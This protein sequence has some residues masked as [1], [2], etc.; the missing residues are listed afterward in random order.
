MVLMLQ[1]LKLGGNLEFSWYSCNI[2]KILFKPMHNLIDL[3][4]IF[5]SSE[6]ESCTEKVYS[7][8]HYVINIVSDLRQVGGIERDVRFNESVIG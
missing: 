1:N 2:F 5:L 3:K 7:I 6:F 4:A 8:Q